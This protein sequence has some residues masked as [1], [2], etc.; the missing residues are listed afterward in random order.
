M[1]INQTVPEPAPEC[2]L[3]VMSVLALLAGLIGGVGAWAFR[4][5]IG[6]VHNVLFLGNFA[7][8]Y[9]ANLHTVDS[10]W[11]AGIILVP[12][13]GGLV[14][15][16]LVSNFAPEAK[17]HGVPEVMDAIHHNQGLIRPRVALVKSIASAISIGSGAAVGREGP[18]IQIGSAFGSML[19]QFIRMPARQRITLIA[20]GSGA[21]IAATFNAPLGGV[22]FAMEL[23]LVSCNARNVFLVAVATVT[24]THISHQLLGTTPSFYIPQLE[25]PDF[26]PEQSASL[27]LFVLL[28]VLTGL[29]SVAFIRMLYRAEDLF[30]A[31]PG[32]YYLRHSLGMALVGVMIYLLMRIKGHYFVQGVGYATIMD[33]LSGVLADPWFLLLLCALKLAA[34]SLS[35]G[36]GASGGIF[37]PVLFIGATAGS[38]FGQLALLAFPGIQ[39]GIP[40]FA[41]A[42]M[43]GGIGGTSGAVLTGVI[44]IVEMTRDT[45]VILP[46]IITVTVAAAT[47]KSIMRESVY[48]LKLTRRGHIVPEGL[49][50]ALIS[51]ERVDEVMQPVDCIEAD[52]SADHCQGYWIVQRD[53]NIEGVYRR[54]IRSDNTVVIHAVTRFTLCAPDTRF[55]VAIRGLRENRTEAILISRNPDA[56]RAAD[57][58]GIL[59]VENISHVASRWADSI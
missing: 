57:V 58:T 30:D 51:A 52:A 27:F 14:V 2:N 39:M 41:I 45:N 10:P 7:F 8:D 43:A 49:E 20:A 6:L 53:G 32:N 24:A 37:S 12:V 11:G 23:L 19:G 54:S 50:A 35:L 13:A 21:G 1:S 47:R 29:L 59:T 22:V 5:L 9:N 16:W 31:I 48:T 56:G 34:T 25:L 38:A 42:G 33:I 46:V 18:I 4:M 28:G 15:A 40:A 26:S 44:M 55:F 3:I 17:G 36:S